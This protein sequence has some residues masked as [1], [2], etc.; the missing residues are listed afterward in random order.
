VEVRVQQPSWQ[1]PCG[2]REERGV[3]ACVEHP[4][5]ESRRTPAYQLI[6]F[7]AQ[8]CA[9]SLRRPATGLRRP[10]APV[11]PTA[12][13]CTLSLVPVQSPDL[14]QSI[15]VDRVTT[16][17]GIPSTAASPHQCTA[18]GHIAFSLPLLTTGCEVAIRSLRSVEEHEPRIMRHALSL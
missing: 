5:H 13:E 16:Y 4:Q 15:T 9:L 12:A 14:P 11:C 18:S 6:T 10:F 8:P 17:K 7:N 3:R 1:C 2:D